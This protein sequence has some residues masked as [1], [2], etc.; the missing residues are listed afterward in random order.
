MN[1]CTTSA[2][3][4]KETQAVSQRPAFTT[5]ET[6]T[7]VTLQ[8]ALPGVRKEH[9]KVTINQSV[10]QL[11]ATRATEVP[12]DWKAHSNHPK[13][14][15]YELGFQL[16]AKLDGGKVQA[17]LENGVLTLHIPVREEAKARDILVN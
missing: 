11:E 2:C 14:V 7:G 12:D 6:E 8:V 17:G 1:D 5:S 3:E 4:T 13:K 10:L 9:L 16:A 15:S